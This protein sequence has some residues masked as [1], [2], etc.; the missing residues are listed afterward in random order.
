[1]KKNKLGIQI[2]NNIYGPYIDDHS[3][4]KQTYQTYV[5]YF[6]V[7]NYKIFGF[8]IFKDLIKYGKK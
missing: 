2:D 7:F 1:M 8:K 6:R 3:I 4:C 5:K